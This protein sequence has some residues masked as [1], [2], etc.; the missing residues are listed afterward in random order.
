MHFTQIFLYEKQ[1]TIPKVIDF[2]PFTLVVRV[3]RKRG[4]YDE[5]CLVHDRRAHENSVCD[6]PV[7][8]DSHRTVRRA[9]IFRIRQLI[10]VIDSQDENVRCGRVRCILIEVSLF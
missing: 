7:W 2:A 3:V 4:R 5:H 6:V 1:L 8:L 10:M 9:C